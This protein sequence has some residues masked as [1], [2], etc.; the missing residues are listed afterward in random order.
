[1]RVGDLVTLSARGKKL[2]ACWRW[3]RSNWQVRPDR[4]PKTA[5]NKLVG[6]LLRIEEPIHAFDDQQKYIVNWIS[7]GPPHREPHNY[8]RKTGYWHRCDLKFVAKAK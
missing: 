6:L 3:D 1:M 7:D 2:E 8:S 4:A 5:V